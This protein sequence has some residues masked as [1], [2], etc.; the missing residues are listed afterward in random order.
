MFALNSARS[1]P[2]QK[3]GPT[4][5]NST[6]RA[7]PSSRARSKAAVNAAMSSRLKALRLSGRLMVKS[8]AGGRLS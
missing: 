2:A 5:V 6:H 4:P 1:M 7:A 8:T 3:A